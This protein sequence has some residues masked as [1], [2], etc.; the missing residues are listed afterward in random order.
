MSGSQSFSLNRTYRSD[1]RILELLCCAQAAKLTQSSAGGGDYVR[2]GLGWTQKWLCCSVLPHGDGG[3]CPV[4]LLALPFINRDPAGAL[5]GQR[6]HG[7][8]VLSRYQALLP[9]AVAHRGHNPAH[10][11]VP[12][13]RET[14]LTPFP[15]SSKSVKIEKCCGKLLFFFYFYF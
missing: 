9:I 8:S 1:W 14:G 15:P 10:H 3:L 4:W 12:T 2:L 5:Q 6:C 11:L 7:S 13:W